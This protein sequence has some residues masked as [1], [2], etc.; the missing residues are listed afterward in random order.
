MRVTAHLQGSV[1]DVRRIHKLLESLTAGESVG[2]R[3]FIQPDSPHWRIAVRQPWRAR[4]NEAPGCTW[5]LAF[6]ACVQSVSVRL[7]RERHDEAR[8]LRRLVQGYSAS[9]APHK[10]V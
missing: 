9:F 5:G 10:A 1:P 6:G 4:I 8:T 2:D 3:A 7:P